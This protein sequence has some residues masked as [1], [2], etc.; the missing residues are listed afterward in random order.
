M[1]MIDIKGPG[2]RPT[3]FPLSL[4]IRSDPVPCG[5]QFP[6]QSFLDPIVILWKTP[7]WFLTQC[8][9]RRHDIVEWTTPA[10]LAF[11]LTGPTFAMHDVIDG[12]FITW[13]IT[14]LIV[15]ATIQF[16]GCILGMQ[17]IIIIRN[18][19]LKG[20]GTVKGTDQPT[21]TTP[22]TKITLAKNVAKIIVNLH[23]WAQHEKTTLNRFVFLT[24]IDHVVISC[25]ECIDCIRNIHIVPHDMIGGQQCRGC[26][27]A[28]NN[29]IK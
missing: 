26:I 20:H 7:P 12:T 29:G 1:K 8:V 4:E 11:L 25:K 16:D 3:S 28:I 9:M 2:S 22:F 14:H 17:C 10:I 23:G 27:F 21:P 15:Y 19:A 13:I 5:M 24:R 18:N 6:T